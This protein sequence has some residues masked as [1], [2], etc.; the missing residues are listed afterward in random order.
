ML[1]VLR[2]LVAASILAGALGSPL[3]AWAQNGTLTF[4]HIN[5]VYEIAPVNGEGGFAPLMT[6]LRRERA[7]DAAAVTTVGGDFLSPSLLLG[8]TKGAPM[9]ALFNAIK[10][11]AVTFGN[12]EFDFGPEVMKARMAESAFP[13]IGT[14]LAM[15]DGSA[16]AATVPSWTKT[17]DGITVGFLGL[18]TPDT[19][20]ASSPG[21]DLR[22]R[23]TA[24]AAATAVKA[25]RDGGASVVVALTHQTIAEDR[26]L[27]AR[28]KGID[29]ILGGHDHDPICFYEGS[30]LIL[31]AGHNARYLGV[32][33]LLVSTKATDKGPVTTTRPAEWRFVSTAG[34][35]ADPEIGGIVE[36]Y[37]RRLDSDLGAA[38]G[39]TATDLDS[40]QDS[41]R[42]RESSMGN[43]IADA[44]RAALKADAAIVNGG[45]IRANALHPAGTT[46]T[47][48]DVFA[49][50]PFGN[51]GVLVE[52]SGAE[53][54]AALENGV[55]KVA[56][57]AGRFPQVSGLTMV[58]DPATPPGRRV[59]AVT[60]GGQPLDPARIYR[61]ATNDYLLKGGD[62][63]D[64]FKRAKVLVDASG[65][66]LLA[67]IVMNH[68]EAQKT[69]SP[70]VEG[71]IVAK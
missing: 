11:D 50:L 59:S 28:V 29:L 10:V 30:T 15:A 12:H 48:K 52:M 65:A 24:E 6:L 67:T 39:T 37:T 14:N 19:V 13:W 57:K 38:I 49:E 5:D 22:F 40:R 51:L 55:S 16:F 18:V 36:G 44:L 58:Y 34:V 56:D 60:V 8:V 35:T 61:V 7:Q 17:V 1:T 64:S 2:S 68:V 54:L 62:G 4:L 69:V 71:R 25:L 47:R 41:V 26:D 21:P 42:S 66:M 27:A 20:R 43:L 31:K 46:L 23:P 70:A 45:G 9:V 32:I 53:L 63:Y 33:K 3:N